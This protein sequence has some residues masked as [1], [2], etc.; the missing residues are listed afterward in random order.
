MSFNRFQQSDF[1]QI[2]LGTITV[3]AVISQQQIVV[4]KSA[5]EVAEIAALITVQINSTLGDGSGV[6]IAKAGQKY[7]VLTVNH[8]VE[9]ASTDYSIR[10]HDGENHLVKQVIRLQTD[11]TEPDL[12]IVEFESNSDY[13]VAMLGDS[14]Q[15][16]IGAQIYVYGYPATGGL[17]GAEREPELSPGLV[18]SRPKSRPEG[19]NLRYQA[20]TWSGMS[21]GPVFDAAGR[22]VGLHGQGEFGFAQTSSGDVAPI[23]TG[24]NAAI[25]I[26]LFIRQLSETQLKLEDIQIDDTPTTATDSTLSLDNPTDAKTF[27]FRGLTFLDQGYAWEAIEDF[28]QALKHDPNLPEAYFNLGLARTVLAANFTSEVGTV[29]GSNPIPDYTEAIRL[30]PGYAD[31]YYNRGLA[32]LELKKL[33]LAIADFKQAAQLYRQLGREASYRDAV[34]R[35]Q[36]LETSM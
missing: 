7:T 8:V 3:A 20:V 31:A 33:D 12:A 4:A 15:A 17:T 9:D 18:T 14:E 22:V 36:E 10:T 26:N 2:L 35:I 29:R 24:F 28:N 16:V 30:N 5:Q 25:P 1:T 19:Y 21:G 27:F 23:K 34:N 13:T 6:I 11:N 32:Y